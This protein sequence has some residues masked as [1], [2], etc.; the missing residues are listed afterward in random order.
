M[1]RDLDLW[2]ELAAK[3]MAAVGISITTLDAD[4]ARTLEPRAPAP[5]TRLRMIRDLSRAGVPVRVMVA[6]VIPG[7]TDEEIPAILKAAKGAGA[8]AAEFG[9]LRGDESLDHL[10]DCG[11]VHVEDRRRQ[12]RSA[13]APH[14]RTPEMA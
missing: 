9:Q 8:L 6:P 1:L 2:A 14:C 12:P 11:N 10:P 7:L 4:L 5:A 3:D 13:H